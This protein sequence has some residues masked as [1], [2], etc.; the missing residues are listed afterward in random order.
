MRDVR[1]AEAR[2]DTSSCIGINICLALMAYRTYVQHAIGRIEKLRGADGIAD[3]VATAEA[4]GVSRPA[5]WISGMLY[6]LLILTTIVS[7]YLLV[8]MGEPIPANRIPAVFRQR[9]P[10]P[11]QD[12]ASVNAATLLVKPLPGLI[13]LVPSMEHRTEAI[14]R[15]VQLV[16]AGEERMRGSRHGIGPGLA[17]LLAPLPLLLAGCD[18]PAGTANQVEPGTDID[19]SMKLNAYNVSLLDLDLRGAK[20]DYQDQEIATAKPDG[21]IYVFATK[22]ESWV[23][24]LDRAIKMDGAIPTVDPAAERFMAALRALTTRVKSLDSYYRMGAYLADDLARGKREDPLVIADYDRAIAAF[25]PFTHALARAS[26]KADETLLRRLRAE[27]DMVGYYD[28]AIQNRAR[29]LRLVAAEPALSEDKARMA[30]ADA[31][32]AQTV[33]LLD[34]ARVV[35]AAAAAQAAKAPK[36][37]DE[38]MVSSS[39]VPDDNVIEA[40][41]RMVGTYRTYQRPDGSPD[42]DRER[43]QQRLVDSTTG[44]ILATS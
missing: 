42:R 4:G 9:P 34:K 11:S 31:I 43:E 26:D 38:N 36:A 25:V 37:D 19:V 14:V 13:R 2:K 6:S 15:S 1:Y 44:V 18:L 32:V 24:E 28:V 27:G 5:A 3:L 10:H 17:L 23:E 12:A 16:R 39:A 40:T 22:L 35:R 41:E 20:K 21:E 29:A 30:R 33:Q 8:Q 7:I